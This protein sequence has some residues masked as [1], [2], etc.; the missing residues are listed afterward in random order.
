MTTISSKPGV[1]TILR[2]HKSD[3]GIQASYEAMRSWLQDYRST[4]T[5]NGRDEEFNYLAMMTQPHVTEEAILRARFYGFEV[6]RPTLSEQDEQ[7]MSLGVETTEQALAEQ[8]YDAKMWLESEFTAVLDY[9]T[10]EQYDAIC[11]VID[12]IRAEMA[13]LEIEEDPKQIPDFTCSHCETGYYWPHEGSFLGKNE[14]EILCQTCYLQE[15]NNNSPEG[16]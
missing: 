5:P 16:K 2:R 11:A 13:A 10:R 1:E 14:P 15:L 8:E 12:P 6:V 4:I 3:R 7:R 9:L